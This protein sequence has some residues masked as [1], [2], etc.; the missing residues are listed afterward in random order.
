MRARCG[1]HTS[2]TFSIRYHRRHALLGL[3][4]K[5]A[6]WR[7]PATEREK[8]GPQAERVDLEE[9]AWERVAQQGPDAQA[10]EKVDLV[11]GGEE[12]QS[13][14]RLLTFS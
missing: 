5:E 12:V 10:M 14:S 7:A 11:K 1:A 2:S 9:R 8:S 4:R 6:L 3:Q 13:N